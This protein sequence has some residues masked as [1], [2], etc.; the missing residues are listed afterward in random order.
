M[1]I[2]HLTNRDKY[3][4]GIA[5]YRLHLNLLKNKV[6]SRLLV[7]EKNHDEKE[8]LEIIPLNFFSKIYR[9]VV[10]LGQS[11]LFSHNNSDENYYFEDQRFSSFRF[12]TI[13]KK[14]PFIPDV[15]IVHWISSFINFRHLYLLQK[16]T[17]ALIV[18]HL[19][20]MGLI[21]GG[22]H[23]AWD[24]MNY[25]KS[26]G[27]CPAL[28][29]PSVKDLSYKIL[30]YKKKYVNKLNCIVIT[31]TQ[32]L[33][34]Q[35]VRSSLFTGIEKEKI[36]LGIDEFC[37]FPQLKYESKKVL[38]I[39]YNQKTILIGAITFRE[40]RKGARFL[41]EA[42]EI[43]INS[44]LHKP[45]KITLIIAGESFPR[46]IDVL[47]RFNIL[48]TGYIKSDHQLSDLYRA[49]DIFVSASIEDS[50]PMMINE[51]I[52]SGTPVVSFEMG[53][54]LDL[55]INGKTGYIAKNRDSYDLAFGIDKILN[56]DADQY[57][58][59][60]DNCRKIGLENC[61]LKKQA[62]EFEKVFQR[63]AT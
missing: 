7:I 26:C 38:K 17:K 57:N 6:N 36:L 45:E 48:Q 24:C 51:S 56:L 46:K 59:Y 23:Y 34:N 32:W 20:D 42:L 8:I 61:S 13:I 1:N 40:E 41:I 58:L 5:A 50:G 44:F 39:K 43:L 33:L 60:S 18:F 47:N 30:K 62:H 21:T 15:I 31:P 49:A 53:A 29:S 63:K 12:N 37:F 22:C 55:V 9:K 16:R 27:N 2:L 4:A 52:I 10:V 28:N 25:C 11:F 3:G 14:I 35:T 54:A 19:L